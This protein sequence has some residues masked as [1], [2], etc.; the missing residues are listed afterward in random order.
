MQIESRKLEDLVPYEN[1]PR[2]NDHAIPKV[3]AAITEFGFRVPLLIK[4]DGTIIDGHL[5]YKA[6]ISAGLIEVPC[7][8]A[9]GMS[10]EQ[11]RAFRISVNKVA[12][13]AKW[14][15]GLLQ[16]ELAALGESGFDLSVIG[17]DEYELDDLL[18]EPAPEK[19]QDAVPAAPKTPTTIPGDRWKLGNHILLC[20]DST[21]ATDVARLMGG[22]MADMVFTDPPYNVDYSGAAGKIKNDKMSAA[23]FDGFLSAAFHAMA[24]VLLPGGAVYVAHAD[25]GNIGVSFRAAFLSAN[26]H[27]SAC[28]IWR[29]NQFTLSRSD[30]QWMHE[31]ILY[32]WKLGESHR[33]YGGG[34]NGLSRSLILPWSPRLPIGNTISSMETMSWW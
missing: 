12:E 15:I 27:L 6:A 32:G 18:G 17:Y 8:L 11:I 21:S 16:L 23:E 30:Y 19:D 34:K 20:A 2:K 14:D 33:Y 13:L 28:L 24:G 26:F 10:E 5:R 31:P 1:N 29:K 3:V 25:S 9:D 7:L 4:D 22:D